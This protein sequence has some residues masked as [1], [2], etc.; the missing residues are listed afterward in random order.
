MM[1]SNTITQFAT[2]LGFCVLFGSL[3]VAFGIFVHFMV[4]SMRQS[5]PDPEFKFFYCLESDDKY[6]D[7]NIAALLRWVHIRENHQNYYV[8][9]TGVYMK[10]VRIGTEYYYFY[11]DDLEY[12][13]QQI[14]ALEEVL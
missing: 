9:A 12:L 2:W 4:K 11:S 6:K 8:S 10:R 13:E 5:P 7:L 3:F 1:G 14:E